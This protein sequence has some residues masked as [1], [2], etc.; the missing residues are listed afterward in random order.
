MSALTPEQLTILRE[1]YDSL[2][3]CSNHCDSR[4]LVYLFSLLRPVDPWATAEYQGLC[5]LDHYPG[6]SNDPISLAAARATVTRQAEDSEYAA[7][8][9][10]AWWLP[11]TDGMKA[12]ARLLGATLRAL[13]A[14]TPETL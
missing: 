14:A 11:P 5:D 9:E 8:H 3:E 2:M 7:T 1:Y 4:D 6:F 13:L 12:E 10:D